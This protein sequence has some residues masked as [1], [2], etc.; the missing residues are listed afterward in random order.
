[1]CITDGVVA[2]SRISPS[3]EAAGH[4]ADSAISTRLRRVRVDARGGCISEKIVCHDDPV[5]ARVVAFDRAERVVKD[6]VDPAG[7]VAVASGETAAIRPMRERAGSARGR[8]K[9]AGTRSDPV[10]K[11][12]VVPTRPERPVKPDRAVA[13]VPLKERV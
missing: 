2:P 4:G 3:V 12:R 7:I 13:Q 5:A 9:A 8:V 6:I 1:M 10:S 11:D